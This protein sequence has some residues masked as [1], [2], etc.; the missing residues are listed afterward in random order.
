MKQV[1]VSIDFY[2]A[3]DR[4]VRLSLTTKQKQGL[5]DKQLG[6]SCSELKTGPEECS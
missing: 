6:G 1:R 4:S 2:R 5:S 3:F